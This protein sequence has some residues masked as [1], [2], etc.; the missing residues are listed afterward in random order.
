MNSSVPET[1]PRA[2]RV[3][4]NQ[5]ALVVDL[6]DGRR[7]RAPRVKSADFPVALRSSA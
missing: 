4:I 5:D 2:E 3:E 7:I 6:A 1:D